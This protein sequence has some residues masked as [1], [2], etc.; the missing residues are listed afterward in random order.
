MTISYGSGTVA[1]GEIAHGTGGKLEREEVDTKDHSH[2]DSS[3]Q[4]DNLL[5][6]SVS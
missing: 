2:G 4:C 5:F 1:G 6:L 3:L